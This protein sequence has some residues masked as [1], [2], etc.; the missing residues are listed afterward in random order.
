MM[1]ARMSGTSRLMVKFLAGLLCVVAMVGTVSAADL[2]LIPEELPGP[3]IYWRPA[4]AWNSDLVAHIFYRPPGCVP[5]DFNLLEF[6]DD[7]GAYSCPLL[8]E[9]FSIRDQEAGP[10][11]YAQFREVELVPIWITTKSDYQDAIEDGE[12]TTEE[13]SNISILVLYA[14]FYKEILHPLDA[15]QVPK[16]N[17]QASGPL[18]GGSFSIQYEGGS[19]FELMIK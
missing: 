8:V 14:D 7:P 13:L 18:G 9:G 17:I 4:S 19:H 3:P 11:I 1:N 10:P 16:I 6:F 5:D 12:L 15:A 2:Y